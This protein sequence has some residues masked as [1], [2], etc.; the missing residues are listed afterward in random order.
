MTYRRA[1]ADDV[2]VIHALLCENAR[3]DNGVIA[4]STDTLLRHGFGSDPKFRV[5]LA[6]Q[7]DEALGL[8]LFFPEYSSWR[9]TVGAFVQDLY[10]RPKARG[11]GLGRALLAA[12]QRESADWDSTFLTLMVQHKNK[13]GQEFYAAQGFT[14]RANADCLICEGAALN[15]LMAR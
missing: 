10:V 1:A 3:N 14:L 6:E 12:V 2:A 5:V 8:A 7:A 4:G 9:G 15:T 11:R 13:K